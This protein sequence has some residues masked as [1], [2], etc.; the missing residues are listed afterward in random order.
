MAFALAEVAK[1]S[2]LLANK[3]AEAS[4]FLKTFDEV[5]YMANIVTNPRRSLALFAM[6]CAGGSSNLSYGIISVQKRHTLE[7]TTSAKR[8][9]QQDLLE[10]T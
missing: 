2:R 10:A 6:W 3:P 8:R 9:S 1:L 7:S 4:D 5:P